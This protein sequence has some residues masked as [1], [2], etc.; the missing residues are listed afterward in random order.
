MNKEN[1]WKFIA[2]NLTALIVLAGVIGNIA[3]REA[4]SVASAE[5]TKQLNDR[6]GEIERRF[7]SVSIIASDSVKSVSESLGEA[8]RELGK[9]SQM[10][11]QIKSIA[12]EIAAL[13]DDSNFSLDVTKIKIALEA[14]GENTEDYVNEYSLLQVNINQADDKIRSI[15]DFIRSYTDYSKRKIVTKKI[16]DIKAGRTSVELVAPVG[17]IFISSGWEIPPINGSESLLVLENQPNHDF[18]KW[19]FNIQGTAHLTTKIDISLF[20]IAVPIYDFE[21]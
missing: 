19:K 17:Y 11:E 21:K 4:A 12:D 1:F 18:T 16:L 20:A 3:K 10:V 5:I 7:N 9:A 14:L 13:G 6:S 15:S 2:A 8:N